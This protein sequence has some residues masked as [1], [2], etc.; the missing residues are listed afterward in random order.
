MNMI[1]SFVLL[2]KIKYK[3]GMCSRI[4][5]LDFIIIYCNICCVQ[6]FINVVITQNICT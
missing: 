3:G 4:T 6:D 5:S 2:F 1:Y